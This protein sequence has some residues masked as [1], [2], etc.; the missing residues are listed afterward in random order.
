MF[1][2]NMDEYLDEEVESVNQAFE[3]INREWE[4]KVLD[5]VFLSIFL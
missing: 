4:K 1:E 3:V 2:A 5:P